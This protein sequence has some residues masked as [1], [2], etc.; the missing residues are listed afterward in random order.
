MRKPQDSKNTVP[1]YWAWIQDVVYRW[2]PHYKSWYDRRTRLYDKF[3]VYFLPG[4]S[5]FFYQFWDIA[6][7]FKTLAILPWFLLYVRV[8]DRTLDPDFKETYLRDMIYQNPEI[9]KLFNEDTIHVLDYD[10]E[11]DAGFKDPE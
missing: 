5:L 8:R 11:Y 7:G 4:T 6:L 1:L 10:C 3:S 9:T 2:I